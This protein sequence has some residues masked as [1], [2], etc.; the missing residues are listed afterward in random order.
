MLARSSD[1]ATSHHAADMVQQ[2]SASQHRLILEALESGSK[3]A[4]QIEAATG[5]PAYGVR[6]R[7]SELLSA[8]L[9]ELTGTTRRTRSGRMERVWRLPVIQRE[10]I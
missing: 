10:L 8:H 2:F 9:I 3:G 4:E 7:T 1:P 5:I 6:K